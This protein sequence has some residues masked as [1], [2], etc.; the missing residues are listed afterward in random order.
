MRQFFTIT[1]VL[2]SLFL[3][4]AVPAKA[5]E[6]SIPPE[7]GRIM[8]IDGNWFSCEFAHSQIPPND[9][10][11]MLDDDGFI[12]SKG[13]IVHIKVK[14]SPETNCRHDRKGQ[15]FQRNMDEIVVE[16][17]PLGEISPTAGGFAITYWGCTQE[18]AMHKRDGYF[19]VA[20]S[21]D[22]CLWTRDKRY[23]ITRFQ[24]RLQAASN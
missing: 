7:G 23:F 13:K 21:G 18:Y 5:V 4:H 3:V 16:K 22:H 24:G 10:C 8:K 14:N 9:G 17:D 12:V 2:T 6:T 11:Q 15:C 1:L 19:E 20:P